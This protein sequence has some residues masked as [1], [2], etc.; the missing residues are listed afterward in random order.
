MKSILI[1]ENSLNSLVRENKD[2][3]NKYILSGLFAEFGIKNRNDRIY[4][5]KNFYPH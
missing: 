4:A 5:L 3:N 1:V 2:S